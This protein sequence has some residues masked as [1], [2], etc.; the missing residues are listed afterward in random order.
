M[1]WYLSTTFFKKKSLQ[2]NNVAN[3]HTVSNQTL[4]AKERSS[5]LGP[6]GYPICCGF[7]LD[8]GTEMVLVALADTLCMN[9]GKWYASWLLQDLS[10]LFDSRLC[11]C[12]EVFE[13]RSR[14]QILGMHLGLVSIVCHGWNHPPTKVVK[15]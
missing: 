7:R 9:V 5:K 8:H 11:H 15:Y 6:S 13:C 2:K 1:L 3:Y 10:A 14:Y 4:L 12:A